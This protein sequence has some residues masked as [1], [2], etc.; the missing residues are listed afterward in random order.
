[1]LIKIVHWLPFFKGKKLLSY[2]FPPQ[3]P[4]CFCWVGLYSTDFRLT[5]SGHEQEGIIMLK[6][7]YLFI[8]IGNVTVPPK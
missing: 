4:A 3:N 2:F 5:W 1:M 6:Y 7:L 8:F